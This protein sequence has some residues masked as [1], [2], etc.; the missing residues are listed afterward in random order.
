[1]Q[2][3]ETTPD[4]AQEPVTMGELCEAIMSGRVSAVVRDGYYEVKSIEIRGMRHSPEALFATLERLR[5]RL[6]LETGRFE[7]IGPCGEDIS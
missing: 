2:H 3:L 6:P 1:M 5:P 4:A 7:E